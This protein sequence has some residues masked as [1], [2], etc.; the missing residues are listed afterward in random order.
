M[1]IFKLFPQFEAKFGLIYCDKNSVRFPMLFKINVTTTLEHFKE[2]GL[3]DYQDAKPG[4]YIYFEIGLKQNY[5]GDIT[6]TPVT[7]IQCGESDDSIVIRHH[8]SLES[9]HSYLQ[10]H[11]DSKIDNL[12]T[13]DAC[14]YT[15][16]ESIFTSITIP[17]PPSW[18]GPL[19]FYVTS[20][21]HTYLDEE[22]DW[23]CII[24]PDGT[25][26]DSSEFGF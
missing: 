15:T 25:T 23:A 4:T 24:G 19:V 8:K 9:A 12:D 13:I 14:V 1:S 2:A 11:I 20:I 5:I 7:H 6:I 10:G 17:T 3:E 18:P 16:G 21:P 22:I 26:L